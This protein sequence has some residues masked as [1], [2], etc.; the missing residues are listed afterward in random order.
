[1]HCDDNEFQSLTALLLNADFL[2]SSLTLF[3]QF[4]V[5]S[6]STAVILFNSLSADF[7]KSRHQGLGV[8][9]H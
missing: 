2:M 6:F 7:D 8:L 9:Q 3:K 4:L 1:M 5:L